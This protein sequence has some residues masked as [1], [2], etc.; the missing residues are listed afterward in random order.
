MDKNTFEFLFTINK[1]SANY[2]IQ[3]YDVIDCFML[4][5]ATKT[6][7]WKV[8]SMKSIMVNGSGLPKLL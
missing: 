3:P 2:R 1:L 8:F 4:A 6:E 7:L 5:L